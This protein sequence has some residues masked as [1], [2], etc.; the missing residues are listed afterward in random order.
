MNII[1]KTKSTTKKLVSYKMKNV[2]LLETGA[3]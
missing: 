1:P 2:D 3:N